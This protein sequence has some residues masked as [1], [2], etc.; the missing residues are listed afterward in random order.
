MS[1][2]R[3][4]GSVRCAPWSR[5]PGISHAIP[6]ETG[7]SSRLLDEPAF[8][9]AA[10]VIAAEIAAMPS[11]DYAAERLEAAVLERQN[12]RAYGAGEPVKA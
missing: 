12:V 10:R 2:S 1:S 6:S 11:A 9:E 8:G 5:R 3:A 4:F 7:Q